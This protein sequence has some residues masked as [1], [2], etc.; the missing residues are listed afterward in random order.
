MCKFNYGVPRKMQTMS[1][2]VIALSAL[3]ILM[4]IVLFVPEVS[5]VNAIFAVLIFVLLLRTYYK[6]QD[7]KANKDVAGDGQKDKSAAKAQDTRF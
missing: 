7:A 2:K 6:V 3:S 4:T 1:A 5:Q